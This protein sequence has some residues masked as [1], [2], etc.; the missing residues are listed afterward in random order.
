MNWLK[1][2]MLSRKLADP[3]FI[4]PVKGDDLPW[5]EFPIRLKQANGLDFS[6]DWSEGFSKLVKTLERNHLL[7]IE[8][9][10]EVS[11]I[12]SLSVRGFTKP[13]SANICT[14]RKH[15]QIFGL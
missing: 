10:P 13:L 4:I 7:R 2:A 14:V 6:N 15:T 1:H 5:D 11:R 3:R 9:E 12:A 8:S